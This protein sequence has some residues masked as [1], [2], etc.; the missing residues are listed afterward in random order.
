M[1]TDGQK[2]TGSADL[3]KLVTETFEKNQEKEKVKDE[4]QDFSS[5]IMT[6]GAAPIQGAADFTGG[7]QQSAQGGS[8]IDK[9]KSKIEKKQ[10][11]RWKNAE[12]V[13]INGVGYIA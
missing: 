13:I 1:V 11:E 7:K 2:D 12:D 10:E 9:V 5:G 6:G 3:S 4:Q 8:L